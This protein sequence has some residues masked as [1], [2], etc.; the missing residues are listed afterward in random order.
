MYDLL[1]Y[2]FLRIRNNHISAFAAQCAFFIMMSLFPLLMLVISIASHTLV[3][4]DLLLADIDTEAPEAVK[5][6]I[7]TIIKDIQSGNAYVLSVITVIALL[8]SASKGIY[9]LCN[10][11]KITIGDKSQGY[12]KTR[13]LSFA[14]TVIMVVA[15]SIMLVIAVFGRG[16]LMKVMAFNDIVYR[17]I[18]FII[19]F[20]LTTL[21]ITAVY[22]F[23][24]MHKRKFLL[25]IKGGAICALGW[26]LFTMGFSIYTEQIADFNAIYGSLSAI[27]IFMIWLYACMYMLFIGAIIN[28][29]I[30][31]R[32]NKISLST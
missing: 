6:I 27:V 10:G 9:S 25:E 13:A 8:W 2:V 31:K 17:L 22:C 11:L 1:V 32:D 4:I 3:D 26:T 15:I 18:L 29:Y 12:F 28:D 21:F 30:Y 19:G 7:E 20:T 23:L 14:Y 24:P 5:Y 16:L